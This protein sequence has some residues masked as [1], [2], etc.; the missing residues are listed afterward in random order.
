[1]L[2]LNSG[3]T[4]NYFSGTGTNTLT[5]RYTVASGQAS[6]DLDYVATNSLTLNG[7]TIRDVVLNNAVLTLATPGAANSISDD[8][9]IVIVTT[10]YFDNWVRAVLALNDGTGR[11]YV[12]G[13]FTQYGAATVRRLVRLNSDMSLDTAF[14]TNV[15]AITQLGSGEVY[16]IVFAQDGSGDII[17]GGDFTNGIPDRLIRLNSNGTLDT[18][19]TFNANLGSGFNYIVRE[20]IPINDGSQDIYVAG[21]FDQVNGS[22]RGGLVRLN[23]NGTHDAT[24][25]AGMGV[26]AFGGDGGVRG[27]CK[28]EDGSNDIIITGTFTTWA[29]VATNKV[30]RIRADGTRDNTFNT[31]IG[32]SMLAP[33][34]GL[35]CSVSRDGQNKIYIG[36][37]FTE[38]DGNTAA[39]QLTRLNANGTSD[40]ANF[41]PFVNGG[42][43]V[44][45]TMPTG[46][47]DIYYSGSYTSPTPARL[48][49]A[50]ADATGTSDATFT[51]LVDTVAPFGQADIPLGESAFVINHV[52]DGTG[53]IYL[54][55]NFANFAGDTNRRYF[56][57]LETIPSGESMPLITNV[58]ASNADGTYGPDA[59]IN[60]Q[61]TFNEN[62]TLTGTARLKLETGT[63]DREAVC[64]GPQNNVAT[65]TC[66]YTVQ[67]GDSS[68]D[69]S[70]LNQYSLILDSGATIVAAGGANAGNPAVVNI[71][72]P[73]QTG[74]LNLNKNIVIVP[75]RQ[76]NGPVYAIEKSRAFP[77][78]IYV[79][80]DFTQYGVTSANRIIRLNADLSYDSTFNVGTGVPAT[81]ESLILSYGVRV[82]KE[83][84]DGS[85]DVYL[86]GTFSTYN[87]VTVNKLVRVNSNGTIDWGFNIGSAAPTVG[88][89]FNGTVGLDWFVKSIV[90][91]NDGSGD[92]IIAGRFQ[93]YRGASHNK[94]LRINS[95]G[96][97]DAGFSVG[98]TYGNVSGQWT[99]G[100][101]LSIDGS[102]ELIVASGVVGGITA[103]RIS[104]LTG[105]TIQNAVTI[106]STWMESVI[107]DPVNLGQFYAYG[108]G[109]A[110]GK[111]RLIR[112]N[113]SGTVAG[114]TNNPN[115][116]DT[117]FDAIYSPFGDNKIYLSGAFTSVDATA[118][119]RLARVDSLG[120]IDTGFTIGAGFAGGETHTIQISDDGSKLFVGGKFTSYD[121]DTNQAYFTWINLLPA[122]TSSPTVAS[123]TAS[124]PN[125]TYGLAD[126]INIQIYFSENVSLT[127]TARLKLETGN[128]DREAV[129]TG[130]QTNVAFLACTYTVQAEDMSPDL[131]YHSTSSLILDSGAT[132]VAAGGANAGN[133][134]LVALSIP[135]QTG[136][137]NFNKDIV[138][139]S[140]PQFDGPIFTIVKS[141]KYPGKLYLGGDF[142][143][144]GL[145]AV[146]RLVRLN[147]DLSLDTAFNIG[148]GFNNTAEALPEKGVNVVMEVNDGTGDIFVGGFFTTYQGITVNKLVKLND[149]GSID[150][151]FNLGTLAPTVGVSFNGT[152][153]FNRFV[154]NILEAPDASGDI[155]IGGR[156][157]T[158]KGSTYNKVI[159]LNSDGSIDAGF[160]VG[161]TFNNV[162]GD[163]VNDM[164]VAIN[165]SNELHI[166]AVNPVA[167]RVVRLNPVTGALIQAA[168]SM[169]DDWMEG[170]LEDPSNPN[171]FFAFGS[172]SAGGKTRFMQYD[173]TGTV[174]GPATNPNFNNWPDDAMFTPFG[175]NKI[176]VAGN[177]TTV[178]GSGRVGLARINST[179]TLDAGFTI[180][181]GFTGGRVVKLEISDDASKLYVGGMFTAFNG[182]S[183][184]PY[185]TTI[186]LLPAGTTA[187]LITSVTATNPNSPPVYKYP[188]TITIQINFS[189]AV[190]LAGGNAQLR[191]ETGATD[192]LAVCTPQASVTT[193]VCTYSI[194][195][196]DETLDLD[197]SSTQA[198]TLAT[199]A[200]LV[201]SAGVNAGNPANLTLAKPGSTGSLGS[202]KNIE[203]QQLAVFNGPVYSLATTA[204]GKIY[205]GGDFT[206]YGSTS[207]DRIVRL[208]S[209]L[210]LDATFNVTGAGP[211]AYV[212]WI[213]EVNDGS[214]DIYI[215]GNFSNAGGIPSRIA[216]ITNTGSVATTFNTNAGAGLTG[217]AWAVESRQLPN[218]Q[219]LVL[220]NHNQY[221]GVAAPLL[222]R[223][224]PN[225][226]RDA[227]L[228]LGS[229]FTDSLGG[230]ILALGF[231]LT[232][233]GTDDIIIFPQDGSNTPP[234][235]YKGVD[236][237]KG[238]VRISSTGDFRNDSK[239]F[240]DYNGGVAFGVNDWGYAEWGT[241]TSFDG[242]GVVYVKGPYADYNNPGSGRDR[243]SSL[244]ADGTFNSTFASGASQVPFRIFP[245]EVDRNKL[246]ITGDVTWYN[247]TTVKRLFKVN[248]TTAAHDAAFTTAIGTAASAGGTRAV[249]MA[250]DGTGRMF[251]GGTF[252]NFA[253][254]A[255]QDYFTI[256]NT[257]ASG[258]Q[259]R[260]GSVTSS[261]PNGT[262]SSG[263]I[264][265]DL[266]FVDS[267]GSPM[268]VS[269]AGGNAYLSLDTKPKVREAVCT[270]PQTNTSTINCVYTIQ[271]GDN[272]VDLGYL[273]EHSLRVASGATLRGVAAPNNDVLLTL[274]KIGSANSLVAAK[275]IVIDTIL[276]PYNYVPVAKNEEVGTW[277][278]FCVA[279][280]EMKDDGAGNAVSRATSL[281]WT[282]ITQANAI[283]ECTSL[284]ANYSLITNERWMTT[285]REIESLNANWQNGIPGGTNRLS[286][287]N[288]LDGAGAQVAGSDFYPCINV[289][290]T[291]GC[292]PTT[293]NRERRVHYLNNGYAVWDLSGNQF[294]WIDYI[295]PYANQPMSPS[296]S[297]QWY[298]VIAAT[299][300]S[301]IPAA[302][303]TPANLALNNA[304]NSI[305]QYYISNDVSVEGTVAQRSGASSTASNP[306]IYNL[307]F[308]ENGAGT[309]Y[310]TFRCAY[311]DVVEPTVTTVSA[312]NPN[313]TYFINNSLII[314]VQF[315]Q[316]VNVTGFPRI[317]LET[318]A[319][320]RFAVYNGVGSG[321][322][323]LQFAYTVQ[324][325]DQNLDLATAHILALENNGASTIRNASGVHA[326][327]K[328]P[329]EGTAGSLSNSKNIIINGAPGWYQEAYIK[330]ANSEANDTVGESLSL[331]GDTL[332][333]GARFEDS[334]Q[335]TITNGATASG[336]NSAAG[337]GAVYVYQ[338]NGASWGQ[339]AY[340]KASNAQ[341]NDYFGWSISLNGDTLAVGAFF[342]DSNQT[343]ITNGTTSSP[344]NTNSAAGAV[345]VYK[346]TGVNWAQEAYIKPSNND[347]SDLFGISVSLSGNTL[348]VGANSEDSNQITITNGAS[349]SVDNTKSNSGAAYV[350][351]RTGLN[352]AQ[353]AYIKSSNADIDDNFGSYVSISG[354]TI[355]VGAY[356]EDSNQN[357]ITNGTSASADNSTSA[358]GAVYVYRRTGVNWAQEAYIKAS[359]PDVNDQYTYSLQLNGDTLVVGSYLED[360]NQ[361]TI[362]NG[363]TSSSNNSNLESGAVYVY[364]RTG[365]NWAQEAYIKAANNNASDQFGYAVAIS[366]NTLS[367]G[368][369]FESSNQTT[370]TNGTTASSNNSAGNSGAV[371]VY[372]RTGVNWVQEAYIKASNAE[373]SDAFGTAVTISGDTI[374]VSAVSEDSNQTTITNGSLS[375]LDNT[376]GSS[377]AV[378]IYRNAYR[379]FDPELLAYT[380]D[381]DE[382]TIS[383][384]SAG[385]LATGY[386]VAW[387]VG[388][389]PPADCSGGV[390][391]GNVLNYTATGL[392]A[393]TNYSFRV[394]AYDSLSND[395]GGSI[396][397]GKTT[398]ATAIAS[399]TTS[400]AN[401]TYSRSHIPILIDVNYVAAVTLTGT[402]STLTLSSGGTATYLSKPD[403]DTIRF[404]YTPGPTDT[405]NGLAN[406]NVISYNLNGDTLDGSVNIGAA[407]LTDNAH[408]IEI[409]AGWYQEA[410]IKTVNSE[411]GDQFDSSVSISGDT[412]AMGAYAEDSNQ[413][414]ITNGT[415]ASGNNANAQSGAVYV[416]KR[417]GANWTQE[418]YIKAANNNAV[419]LFGS[420]VSLHK[421]TLA[422][423][424]HYEGSNQTTITNGTTASAD[425]STST[426]GAVYVYK[427]TGVNWAQEAYVKAVNNGT[428]Q[429][430]IYVSIS[431]DTLAVGAHLE[432]SNQT[433]I[434]NGTTAS[435]DNSSSQSGAVYVYKRTGV[436]WAQ[437][438][439]IKAANN[440]AFDEFGKK[441]NLNGDTLAVGVI[442]EASNQ[443]TITNGTTASGDNSNAW[444]GAVYV[445]KR[446]GVNWAQEAYIKAVNSE[447]SD[448]F[449]HSVSL[450]GDTLAVGAIGEDGFQNTI[451]NGTTASGLNGYSNSGAVYIY[452]RSGA[453]WA[454]EA[455]IKAANANHNQN[456]GWS[457]SLS[458]NTLVVG[459]RAEDSNQTTITNGTTASTNNSNADSGAAYVYKRVGVNWSQE[460]Y[461]K[462]AN[463]DANDYFGQSV[464]LSGDTIVV[465]SH[466]EASNQTTI[467][468]GVTAS[469]DNSN[470]NAGAA[471]IYRNQ[472][473]L[474]EPGQFIATAV[475][476]NEITLSWEPAG[477]LTV[478]Y[479][480]AHQPGT[481]APADC[482][483]GSVIDVANVTSYTVNGL[484]GPST[485]HSFRICS[486][487]SLMNESEGY[488]ATF[489][490]GP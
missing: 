16:S 422:V 4:V 130:P 43:G 348:V 309:I 227:T 456:F 470:A 428:D 311:I 132:I 329:P 172:G 54:G 351:K 252:E 258:E 481:T 466:N 120:D 198:L 380:S 319:T 109:S 219:V 250:K 444:S 77:G 247:S 400:S 410:Y 297:G 397:F 282:S 299:P 388:N 92:V 429:F 411:A 171:Q 221:A 241:Y 389:V 465:G 126:A 437:E 457:V 223:L 272:S 471:Y 421:D 242:S 420:S 119:N 352:W 155:I 373:A 139:D 97:P 441:L 248:A 375:S 312:T 290:V 440:D 294:E 162:P 482:S 49:R 328:L 376:F 76:F 407:N 439:Y 10:P 284:G 224:N 455:Y 207:V 277:N 205:V 206:Q 211:N 165:G 452:K 129:C 33:D 143:Q 374:A 490:T 87:S 281:P 310:T 478:G 232:N 483:S 217:G 317:L 260:V 191:L 195:T 306:G 301:Y 255:A 353:E 42:V 21:Q 370:I 438:A 360:S 239:L 480:I 214:G 170:I 345:Y 280:F 442:A 464:S 283:T 274:P 127:G 204:N 395:S 423:G 270:G 82:I 203:I 166:A 125:A 46:E 359:N 188:S 344:D 288:A 229:G 335:T 275:A 103:S 117:V 81:T 144:Y 278:D 147:S 94:I 430:G 107:P 183:D 59:V 396:I 424:A 413:T 209:D 434:T 364:K 243:I 386:M 113:S 414:T 189:E 383:W 362:T 249:A 36:G 174:V 176:Y 363:T 116:N 202:N 17:V 343:T 479:I 158:Y 237:A 486:Y 332:A 145:T 366:G 101:E 346:R 53:R 95:D 150:W 152:V 73:G 262:Y 399:V 114:P 458:G 72:I 236:H 246:I 45:S 225:G 83:A 5:F 285:A 320:D 90:L 418:A 467:T 302:S 266:N 80:G 305:G 316:V 55:G 334:N 358:S 416:Y 50:N 405:T 47:T 134:A 477:I 44:I 175:D 257:I 460:A 100:I 433:T 20:I 377:G 303:M 193:L 406:L 347:A 104:A 341:G 427:R 142:T 469:A 314:T 86:G 325:D 131:A 1:Q 34:Y 153:G 372:K 291:G 222:V 449:G 78:K 66:N 235:R 79:G 432:A 417:S 271:L 200:T 387:A 93:T 140:P 484:L 289:T 178:G 99:N 454:Q 141:K 160:S 70:Y 218:G 404:T 196:D 8:K 267:A 137:L 443:T 112:Y 368:A 379:I 321:T 330:T 393:G 26:G 41:N 234:Y 489:M 268:N 118:R 210:S 369:R 398:D 187:P 451:T 463:N 392:A 190:T 323:T 381:D 361:N 461:I 357:T 226:T 115:I 56:T 244:Y 37:G 220:G 448:Q 159:R 151:G 394:C 401:G 279:K 84:I 11:I 350:Y 273:S 177:F 6:A 488:T 40:H 194:Q 146:N 426:A 168:V 135:G 163:W 349:A 447:P 7:G 256:V 296:V 111:T 322:N 182:D 91:P 19:T 240:A 110:G 31:N 339:Q 96:S 431:G 133:S 261:T 265:I 102:N 276:C 324:A 24:F 32:T 108:E 124:N 354:D 230:N 184:K 62:V 89:T 384:N 327:L 121:G 245:D 371:Y 136:S 286:Q 63:T 436:N 51:A 487:D 300:T 468:N 385:Q 149:D 412:L 216:R 14:N 453:N 88:V 180:G 48:T 123:V 233:D 57:Y 157:E 27:A 64:T 408:A 298:D 128:I 419:D 106:P 38:F 382:I 304:T 403:A 307:N 22:T 186:D 212:N 231:T 13:R 402:A 355:A 331:S 446:T 474:F 238:M 333:V 75:Q 342:E 215:R 9:A 18:D 15:N 181:S 315:D 326:N 336:D 313:G 154:K 450:S 337:S 251:I 425:N 197:Y 3:A 12:G 473:R 254:D 85:G 167:N 39:A 475:D 156:F 148:T 185:F 192:E 435:S 269:L 213:E 264:S 445:Y 228:N 356:L 30:A 338:R 179:G 169:P 253:G 52:E 58:T 462:A 287:G 367:V 409:K 74:S 391:V 61:L 105:S 68:A 459:A 308:Q 25:L 173:A 122:G 199:G 2:A 23:N 390:D 35:A 67:V 476:T 292:S 365:V 71:A 161:T 485:N 378:Y 201:A 263:T 340:I 415:T 29:G 60:V 164:K 259:P 98:T 295:V 208:N 138:I 293:W 472:A 28:L 65:I 69:L 318:G